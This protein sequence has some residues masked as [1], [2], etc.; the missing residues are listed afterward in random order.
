LKLQDKFNFKFLKS[1]IL[2]MYSSIHYWKKSAR[3]G[4]KYL[5]QVYLEGI[6]SG[7]L[8]W[9]SYG[10]AHYCM[11]NF[12]LGE[13]LE[14]VY[15]LYSKYE[16]PLLKLKQ[17]D[18]PAFFYPPRQTAA[19]LLGKSGDK[20]K[21]KGEFWDEDEMIPKLYELKY[22]GGLS[23][24]YTFK[25]MLLYILNDYK[26]AYETAKMSEAFT[27]A[28]FG[29]MQVTIFYFYYALSIA[30]IYQN[31]PEEE[32]KALMEKLISVK[33]K[34]EL[35]AKNCP[36]NFLNKFLIISAELER[37]N[38]NDSPAL[39]LYDA[40][41][42]AA[43]KNRYPHEEAISNEL[44]ARFSFSKEMKKAG[45]FYI[46]EAVRCY[47]KWG[48]KAKVEELEKEF[49]SLLDEIS[50]KEKSNGIDESTGSS[51]GID[52][53]SLDIISIIK[54]MQ[55]ISGEILMEN[56]IKELVNILVENAGAQKGILALVKNN[57]LYIEAEKSGEKANI[58]LTG[59][60]PIDA[61]ENIPHSIV[62]YT[63]KTKESIILNNARKESIFVN[64]PYIL[65][66][67]PLSIFSIPIV[68]RQKVIGIIYLENSITTNAFQKKRTDTIKILS[69]QAA[70]AL[71]N[72]QAVA[73]QREKDRLDN[74]MRIAE[75]LQTSLLPEIPESKELEISAF[76]KPAEEVG[77]DYYDIVTD[78]FNNLWVAVGDVSGHGLTPGLIMMMAET[79]FNAK[80]Q[81]AVETLTPKEVITSVNKLLCGNVR[82]RLKENHFMTMVVGKYSGKGKFSYSGSHNDLIL[83]RNSSKITELF[84]TEGLYL[85]ILPDITNKV[86]EF[87]IYLE[88]NDILF[89]YTDGIIEAKNFINDKEL[90]GLER[91]RGIVTTHAEKSPDVIKDIIFQEVNKWTNGRLSDD[92]SLVILKRIK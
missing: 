21:L 43:A 40:A 9:A 5:E 22:Y 14:K 39:K 48:A 7:N 16:I 79:S 12:Y 17:N 32:K 44:A 56:L 65:K 31:S 61:F 46:I 68:N 3:D 24:N 86:K 36:V 50:F 75:K 66:N 84:K 52:T 64:D 76:M 92:I 60:I 25:L 70:I 82:T 69:S 59:S 55:S 27:E 33:G 81:D 63:F 67:Q 57:E 42:D 6:E 29:Q 51:S 1:M 87:E 41:I 73:L 28:N 30:A 37:I 10:I 4:I 8:Q 45:Y 20:F 13:N 77:G 71:E 15:E 80:I 91:L 34:F 85:S 38:G 88:I 90:F 53:T 35:W 26:N 72:A 11:R 19:N 49:P 23:I 54:S 58:V 62:R 78:D 47:R 89:L 83:Y 18:T 74:E 2:F